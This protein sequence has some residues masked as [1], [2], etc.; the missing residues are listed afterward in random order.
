MVYKTWN[1]FAAGTG[2]VV[3]SNLFLL[4]QNTFLARQLLYLL[5]HMYLY[6]TQFLVRYKRK[7]LDKVSCHPKILPD[8]ASFWPDIVH[9]PA[10]KFQA[11]VC[12]F[13][14][15]QFWFHFILLQLL[16]QKE[17]VHHLKTRVIFDYFTFIFSSIA[18]FSPGYIE[19]SITMVIPVLE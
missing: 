14:F 11:L 4:R 13:F 10:V 18:I 12:F 3:R 5:R 15:F 2:K 8:K 9:W 16:Q 19:P 1:N 17:I 7:G 6:D